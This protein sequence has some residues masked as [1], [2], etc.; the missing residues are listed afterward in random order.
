MYTHFGGSSE[1]GSETRTRFLLAGELQSNRHSQEYAQQVHGNP[2][3]STMDGARYVFTT[4]TKQ[5]RTA[6]MAKIVT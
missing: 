2:L 6:Y 5:R 4:K 3:P 1:S